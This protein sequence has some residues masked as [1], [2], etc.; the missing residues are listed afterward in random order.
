MLKK[1]MRQKIMMVMNLQMNKNELKDLGLL[2]TK[3][4]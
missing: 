3:G 2:F 4:R 1:W